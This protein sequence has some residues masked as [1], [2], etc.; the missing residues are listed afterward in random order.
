MPVLRAG[1]SKTKYFQVDGGGRGRQENGSK[2]WDMALMTQSLS[3][4][5]FAAYCD[6]I[7]A[8]DGVPED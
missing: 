7:L 6:M 3:D 8:V 1:W 4:P 2:D 5:L